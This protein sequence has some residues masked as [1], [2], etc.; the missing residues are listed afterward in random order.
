MS[1]EIRGVVLFAVV[2]CLAT[3]LASCA[4]K[5]GNSP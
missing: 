1:L 3:P 2:L 5:T 4:M